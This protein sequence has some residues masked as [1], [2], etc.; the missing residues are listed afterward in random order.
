MMNKYIRSIYSILLR[1]GSSS[2]YTLRKIVEGD[3]IDPS[4]PSMGKET[5]TTDYDILAYKGAHDFK[6]VDGSTI[7]VGDFPLYMSAY[8]LATDVDESYLIVDS[9][10]KEYNI[11]NY[12]KYNVSEDTIFYML[13]LRS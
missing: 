12:K 3:Y 1:Y 7:Q 10:G 8:D 13:N 5:T 2:E 9:S 6:T 4:Q 11:I